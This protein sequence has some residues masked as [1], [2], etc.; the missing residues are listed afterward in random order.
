MN[1][2]SNEEYKSELA[3]LSDPNVVRELQRLVNISAQIRDSS[4]EIRRFSAQDDELRSAV[5]SNE[6]MLRH[7]EERI[8]IAN[9]I[10]QERRISAEYIDQLKANKD[11]FLLEQD[12]SLHKMY[13][14]NRMKE[15]NPQSIQ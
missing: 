8:S 12:K 11:P 3:K 7:Q 14:L 9:A 4:E 13:D 5:K 15:S 10:I 2:L 6:A 1:K